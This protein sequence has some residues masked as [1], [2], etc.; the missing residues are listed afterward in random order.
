MDPSVDGYK[1]GLIIHADFTKVRSTVPIRLK[2]EA[3]T[4]V[5]AFVACLETQLGIKVKVI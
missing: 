4:T 3:V 2:S 1:Y 5:I